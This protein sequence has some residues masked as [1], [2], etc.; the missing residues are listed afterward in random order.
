MKNRIKYIV[1]I[2]LALIL[3][4][5]SLVGCGKEKIPLP[6]PD[7]EDGI[8]TILLDA[9]HGFSDIG[10]TSPNLRGLHEKDLTL[11]YVNMLGEI[12]S[13]KGYTVLYTHDGSFFTKNEEITKRADLLGIEYKPENFID[14]DI[15]SAY[16]RTI[17]SEVLHKEREV[18]LMLSIHINAS[19]DNTDCSWFEIDYCNEKEAS[20]ITAVAFNDISN[21]LKKA[22]PE[23]TLKMFADSFVDSFIVTKYNSMPSILFECGFATTPADA[24]RLL[25][26]DWQE[27]LIKALFDGISDY[28]DKTDYE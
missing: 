5:L 6:P 7:G 20:P 18:D 24:E 14:D 4:S 11:K 15:F 16:E 25:D 2:I 10:C 17:Y 13:S 1:A 21:S 12:L 22:F 27:T 28:F 9:G 23:R 8:A 26:E 19:A 3:T